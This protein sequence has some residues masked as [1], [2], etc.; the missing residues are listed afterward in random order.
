MVVHAENE[1]QKAVAAV[2]ICKGSIC[3]KCLNFTKSIINSERG[4]CIFRNSPVE[5]CDYCSYFK[6]DTRK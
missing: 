3:G 6:E 2:H 1:K 5:R 4:Y